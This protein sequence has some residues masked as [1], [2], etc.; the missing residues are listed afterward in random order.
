MERCCNPNS[1][2]ASPEWL[3]TTIQSGRVTIRS[4]LFNSHSRIT[5]SSGENSP[6]MCCHK[7]NSCLSKPKKTHPCQGSKVMG[8]KFIV[9]TYKYTKKLMATR[10]RIRFSLWTKPIPCPECI[11]LK[12]SKIETVEDDGL[13]TLTSLGVKPTRPIFN[14]HATWFVEFNKFSTFDYSLKTL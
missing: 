6:T 8:W 1:I 11:G 3:Q 4:W 5:T 7:K 13:W 2:H 10:T 12:S 9:K 14:F